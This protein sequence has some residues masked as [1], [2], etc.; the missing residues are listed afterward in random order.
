MDSTYCI[1]EQ[2]RNLYTSNTRISAVT[3]RGVEENEFI[4][5]G[6]KCSGDVVED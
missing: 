3:G 6:A 5:E 1:A 2:A 4:Y